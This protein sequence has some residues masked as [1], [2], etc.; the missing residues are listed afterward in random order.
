MSEHGAEAVQG[1]ARTSAAQRFTDQIQWISIVKVLMWMAFIGFVVW[2]YLK[3]YGD[4][5]DAKYVYVFLIGALL[6]ITEILGRYTDSP[7][8]AM[9]S[10]GAAIYVAVNAFASMAALFLLERLAPGAVTNPIS[11]VLLAGVG[12]MAF[13]RSSVFKAKIANEEVSIGPAIILDTLLKFADAQV[14]RGRAEE[15]ADRIAEVIQ[16]LPLAHAGVDLPRLCFAL[17]QNLALDVRQRTLDDI[18]IIV[19]DTKRSETVKVMEVGLVLWSRVGIGTLTGA[20]TLLK[21]SSLAAIAQGMPG[22]SATHAIV[23][24][25]PQGSP[26]DLLQ[27]IREQLVQDRQAATGSG[28][29]GTGTSGKQQ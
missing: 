17:M 6:G 4:E 25:K 24:P 29:S 20:V 15:R 16:S 28:M 18:T 13:L 21:N 3:N 8:A 9:K 23:P 5:K 11:Q 22:R 1:A 2:F 12:A 10:P 27:E 26:E 19:T 7:V 14:D